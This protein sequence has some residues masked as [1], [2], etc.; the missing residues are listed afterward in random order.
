MSPSP[1]LS[2]CGTAVVARVPEG[3]YMRRRFLTAHITVRLTALGPAPH[4]A[5]HLNDKISS[6]PATIQHDE[7]RWLPGWW[8]S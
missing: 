6:P 1:G 3:I 2:V 4:H 7:L 5:K 8:S